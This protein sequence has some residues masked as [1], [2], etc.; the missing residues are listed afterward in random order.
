MDRVAHLVGEQDEPNGGGED[1]GD[2]Q[3]YVDGVP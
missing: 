2:E 1:V 3:V